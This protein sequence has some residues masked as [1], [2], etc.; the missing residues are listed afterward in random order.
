MSWFSSKKLCS[1]CNVTKTYQKFEGAVTCPQCET[2][3]LISRENIR[4]CPVDGFAMVKEDYRGIILDRCEK[5]KGVWLG[6]NELE[7]IIKLQPNKTGVSLE[8][9]D[10]SID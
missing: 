7:E 9:L 10:M 1:H 8:M 2:K 6:G 5:C 4:N 3:I